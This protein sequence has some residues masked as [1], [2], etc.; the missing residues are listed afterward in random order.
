MSINTTLEFSRKYPVVSKDSK[1]LRVNTTLIETL[2]LRPVI[3]TY[4]TIHLPE[5]YNLSQN[6][7]RQV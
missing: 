1:I 5:Y 6:V 4:R 7:M 3:V 2:L